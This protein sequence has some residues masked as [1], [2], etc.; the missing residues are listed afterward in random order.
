LGAALL[1]EHPCPL[2]QQL[3]HQRR[4]MLLHLCC[5]PKQMQ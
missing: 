5:H 2:L 4:P 3:Q 1:A